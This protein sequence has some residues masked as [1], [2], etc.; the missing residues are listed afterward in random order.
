V[1]YVA[2][3][4]GETTQF[5]ELS[6]RKRKT[7]AL[8]RK[9]TAAADVAAPWWLARVFR[10]EGVTAA[11]VALRPPYHS[12][13]N[14]AD[15]SRRTAL[16]PARKERLKIPEFFAEPHILIVDPLKKTGPPVAA[17]PGLNSSVPPSV[18][19]PLGRH[20]T[21]SPCLP[22]PCHSVAMPLGRHATRCPCLSV[23][24]PL[25]VLASRCPC[26]SV[27]LPLGV[28]ASRCP[29]LSVSLPL[30]VLASRC[31][32]RLLGTIRERMK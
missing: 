18:A 21:R 10:K 16:P 14:R 23:S 29:C 24:L 4:E 1:E 3:D 5:R 32:C 2:R 8:L 12:P 20:A 28:L 7:V 25:G 26:L 19:L 15:T 22:S 6:S 30:G 27:S 31:P 17:C 9:P 11:G 13:L